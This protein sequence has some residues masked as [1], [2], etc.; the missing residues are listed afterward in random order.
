VV[1]GVGYEERAFEHRDAARLAEVGFAASSSAARLP[2]PAKLVTWPERDPL[3][4]WL[5]VSAT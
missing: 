4:L 1:V 2:S 5:N 3:I